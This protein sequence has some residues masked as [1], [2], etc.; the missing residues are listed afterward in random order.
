MWGVL[1]QREEIYSSPF[2]KKNCF[3]VEVRVA[4]RC[5]FVQCHDTSWVTPL[6][7][8]WAAEALGSLL[9]YHLT[10]T[11][12]WASNCFVQ[13]HYW[14]LHVI[15]VGFSWTGSLTKGIMPWIFDKTNLFC[16]NYVLDVPHNICITHSRCSIN[17]YWVTNLEKQLVFSVCVVC[18]CVFLQC[19]FSPWR[20]IIMLTTH[21]KR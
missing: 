16:S 18:V 21:T 9:N 15:K 12:M 1:G 5:P 8:S 7:V 2:G 11:G 4:N 10:S 14:T 17:A 6:N 3:F 13:L 20:S 19:P